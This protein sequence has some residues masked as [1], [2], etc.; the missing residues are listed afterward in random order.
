MNLKLTR[1]QIKLLYV[2]RGHYE[3]YSWVGTEAGDI[4]RLEL[5]GMIFT[6][7]PFLAEITNRGKEILYI[8]DRVKQNVKKPKTSVVVGIPGISPYFVGASSWQNDP[9]TI[10]Q[11]AFI[12]ALSDKYPDLH[13]EAQKI[14]ELE[15]PGWKWE[16][17][18]KA[19]AGVLIGHMKGK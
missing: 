16:T 15:H 17:L 4:H 8:I 6:S 1:Q 10:K 12:S 11:K 2:I 7:D 19:Q 14:L 18:T 13:E 5:E 9:A 3:G